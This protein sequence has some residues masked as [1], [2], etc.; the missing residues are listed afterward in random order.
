MLQVFRPELQ[1][2]LAE[3]DRRLERRLERDPGRNV[4]DDR[5]IE[6]VAAV[7]V[8]LHRRLRELDAL[9]RAGRV[10]R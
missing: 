7:R 3:R 6:I 2:L 5:A 1:A 4:L 8:D 10:R 9:A